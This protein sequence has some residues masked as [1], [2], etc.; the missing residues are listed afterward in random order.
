MATGGDELLELK[1]EQ[2]SDEEAE[3]QEAGD[4]QEQETSFRVY[5]GNLMPNCPEDTLRFLF[6]EHG[7]EV[8]HI[9]V[10]RSYAFVDCEDQANVDKAIEKLNGHKFSWSDMMQ[11]EPS[12]GRRRRSNKVQIRN[13]PSHIGAEEIQELVRSYG[14]VQKCEL[15]G[16]EGLVYVTFDNPEAAQMAVTSLNGIDFQG[17]SIK[18]DFASNKTMR[19]PRP[20]YG[21]QN[22]DRAM[23]RGPGPQGGQNNRAQELPLRIVVGSEFIGAIIGRQGQTIHNI[24]T[25]SRA[26]VDIHRSEMAM[27]P[28]TV[29][30]IKG[31][32]ESCMNACVEI[33]KIVQAE[34]Q[35][36][37]KG[38]HPMKILC[39]NNIC[40]RIIGK[41]GSVIKNFMEQSGTHIVVSSAQD[42]T[43]FTD[44]VVTITGP[45]D[46]CKKGGELLFEKMRKCAELDQQNYQQNMGVYGG[47]GPGGPMGPMF[48][49]G[50]GGRGGPYQQGPYQMQG[51]PGMYQ[52]GP[53]L[54][55]AAPP[56]PP[57]QLEIT[58]LYIPEST[59]GAVI[60][61]KGVNIKNIMRLSNARIKI[62]DQ[63]QGGDNGDKQGRGP[64]RNEE[65]RKV[66]I[67]GNAEA[68][69]KAQFYIAEKIKTETM[70]PNLEDFHF[71]AEILV[72]K[73]MIGR[74][75]GKGGQ[76]VK[77]MQR[78]TQAIVKTPDTKSF[79]DNEEVPVSI[80]GHFYASQ[81]AQRRIRALLSQAM[82]GPPMQERPP[83]QRR[84]MNGN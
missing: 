74:I 81:S 1:E 50:G 59:V 62:L 46:S 23:E 37:V 30:T 47:M 28:E 12:V 26:R 10:K 58:Y 82:Q 77:E 61:T 70:V 84:P 2:G 44:R 18:V 8:G 5:V 25:Q 71:R 51:G 76:H 72:P 29:I 75:I 36:L 52:G 67:T 60:G 45:L 48:G 9:L 63:N 41:G 68:Q 17:S 69:W 15:V 53:G 32:P 49:G 54:Y 16:A 43:Y 13:F 39:P 79:P 31:S 35:N 38:D 19:R 83:N 24:T 57:Q 11:V 33:M 66:I 34:A 4:V 40:G 27:S 21:G 56:Q 80:Y 65:Q 42:A 7:V 78:V 6:E 22:M 14:P 73:P 20:N 55:G 64:H 3:A